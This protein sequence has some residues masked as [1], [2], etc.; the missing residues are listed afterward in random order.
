MRDR[1]LFLSVSLTLMLVAVAC[2]GGE[3]AA[4]NTTTEATTAV[5]EATATADATTEAATG[6]PEPTGTSEPA[7]TDSP[8]A[9]PTDAGAGVLA[10]MADEPAAPL[11]GE[12]VKIGFIT[13]TS[14]SPFAANGQ[15]AQEG[16]RFAVEQINADGG[17]GGVPIELVEADTRGDVNAVANLVRRMATEDNVLAIMG[18]LLS[19]ECAVGC[20]LANQLGVPVLTP[21]AAQ[22]GLMEQARPYAFR[23]VQPDP[24][25]SAPA[26]AAIIEQEGISTAAIIVD[27]QEA[28]AKFMGE[29]FW[30][31]VFEDNGVEVVETVTFTTGESSFA[32]QVTRLAAAQPDAVAL[33]AGPADAA[34]IALEIQSQGLETQLIGS[35]GLQ[36]AG[37]DFVDAG[38]DA[39][40]G[41]KTAAQFDPDDPDPQVQQLRESF[42][43]ESGND[44]VALNT[45]FA[46]DAVYILVDLIKRTGVTN[47]PAALVEDRD[48]IAEGLPTI[49]D[50]VG[51]GGLTSLGEDGEVVRPVLVATV[52]DGRFVI[53]QVDE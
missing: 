5:T 1:A 13:V 41:A 37:Q 48:K 36:S 25:N 35:G 39:V 34:R 12:S 53:E 10:A 7:A 4:T 8:A 6:T 20:P 14:G 21:G 30:P 17:I 52:Q 38:G 45:A 11:Q 19:G 22:P 46:Y 43:E 9:S 23:L 29:N 31:A 16:V 18:P 32:P 44:E 28:I 27:E 42:L 33:A 3:P 15:R 24:A 40:E 2:G 47:D 49:H 50:W 51:M 26:V